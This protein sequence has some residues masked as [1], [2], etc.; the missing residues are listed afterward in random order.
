MAK[1]INRRKLKQSAK[2]SF[3]F[4]KAYFNKSTSVA[5]ITTYISI[6]L[7]AFATL[8]LS[9]IINPKETDQKVPSLPETTPFAFLPADNIDVPSLGEAKPKSEEKPTDITD[10]S[11]EKPQET[12]VEI[13]PEEP[14]SETPTVVEVPIIVEVEKEVVKTVEKPVVKEITKEVVKEVIKERRTRKK[15]MCN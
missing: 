15:G 1:K 14:A 6:L 7:L 4:S 12:A 5:L 11:E 8:G 10:K 9:K 2:S 13:T 3:N